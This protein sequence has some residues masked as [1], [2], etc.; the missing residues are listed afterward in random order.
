MKCALGLL[1]TL[2]AVCSAQVP[3]LGWCPDY[4]PM[5]N[6]DMERFLGKWYESERY[7][8]FSELGTR[9]VVSDYAK[10]ATGK[11]YVSNEV[12]SRIT[13][14][15][16]VLSGD[17]ELAGRAGEGKIKVR[18]QTTPISTTSTLS[19]LDTDY[20]NYA[21]L[22]S[23]SNYGPIYTQNAWV[24]TR[25]RQPPGPVMQK[26]YGVLDRYKISRT[27][28]QRTEQEGCLVAA[29]E[30]NASQGWVS[31]ASQTVETGAAKSAT[32]TLEDRI[33]VDVEKQPEVEKLEEPPKKQEAEK[34]PLN[35]A[36]QILK[37]AESTDKKEEQTVKGQSEAKA[38]Q[39]NVVMSSIILLL[40]IYA[41]QAQVPFGGLCPNVKS[42]EGFQVDK[43]LGKWYE[44]ERYFAIFQFG[45]RCVTAEY[46]LNSDGTVTVNNKQTSS[47]TGTRSGIMGVANIVGRPD[48]GKLSVRFPSLPV[49]FDAPY[50][51]LSTDYDNYSVVWSCVNFGLLNT[52]NLWILTRNRN[53][54]PEVIKKVYSILDKMGIDKTILMKTD[55]QNCSDVSW[56]RKESRDKHKDV[57]NS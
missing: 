3:N 55:Q 34:K 16:R 47:L 38:R 23:C 15:K 19:V 6:F 7:F 21:V 33:D 44:A 18:Y 52:R 14:V 25:E 46:S 36:E 22:W 5:S 24:M 32:P 31:E 42:M 4:V 51:I 13:G 2:L 12:T 28:F 41:V 53:P 39:L 43:Y 56:A 26:A 40:C 30:I 35:V 48:E 9:C 57:S 8:Q 54:S 17:L 10:S 45:G 50:W 49:Q 11:I 27:F 1:V 37:N 29:S 20:D